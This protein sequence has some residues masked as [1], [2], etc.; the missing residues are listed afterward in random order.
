VR[1]LTYLE[2]GDTASAAAVATIMLVV[3]LAAIVSLDL[4]QRRVAR[5]G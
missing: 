2:G 3:A 4:I 5:R 1:M